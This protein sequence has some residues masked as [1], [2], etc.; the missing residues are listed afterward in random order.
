M[1]E[2]P[3]RSRIPAETPE[4]LFSSLSGVPP[5]RT[6]RRRRR[7]LNP[8]FTAG[9]GSGSRRRIPATPLVQWKFKEKVDPSGEITRKDMEEIGEVR[10]VVSA[11]RLAFWIWDL[12]LQDSS[13][14][15]K[16]DLR[17]ELNGNQLHFSYSSHGN[18]MNLYPDTNNE[19]INLP[20]QNHKGGTSHKLEPSA[21]L[22]HSSI[23]K[24]T[25]WDSGPQKFSKE[26]FDLY[27]SL[28]L[29]EDQQSNTISIISFL[30]SE[31]E[32]AQSRVSELEAE[33]QLAKK[34]FDRLIMKIEDAKAA[35]KKS[36]H[37][38][39]QSVIDAMKEDLSRERK[40]RKRLEI[41]NNKLI[42]EVADAKYSAKQFLVDYE[43]ET[44]ARVL[45]EEVCN[46]LAKEIEDDKAEV[47]AL[48]FESLKNREEVE[49][50]RR[51]LQM[52]EVWRE[53]RVQ[54][55]LIDAKIT[56]EEKYSQL[57]R[58]QEEMES[59]LRSRN[60]NNLD[61]SEISQAET[62]KEA[63]G[64]IEAG[65]IKELSYQPPS[66]SLDIFS[67]FEELQPRQE[68]NEKD[69]EQCC[70]LPEKLTNGCAGLMFDRN[71]NEEDDSGWE[72]VSRAEEDQDSSKSPDGSEPS[73]HGVYLE[74]R[75][76]ISGDDPKQNSE[77][78]EVFSVATNQSSKKSSSISRLWKLSRSSNA[79][80]FKKI[81]FEL[82]NG[83]LSNATLSPARKSGDTCL[84]SPSVGNWSSPDMLKSSIREEEMRGQPQWPRGSK[85][86]SLKS[87][88]MEARF[89]SQKIQLRQILEQKI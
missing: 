28:R 29:L 71:G 34:K 60:G 72:T 26:S 52:A 25:K 22:L 79:E 61:A 64:S 37:G 16:K 80:D 69:I 59:F 51:M 23:E 68:A 81:S 38:K 85:K 42:K 4:V 17:S 6:L 50:E 30:K 41:I 11:R 10:P 70:G 56:L 53:E 78:S 62:L 84:S 88:L 74:S 32:S 24:A 18:C 5:N 86:Q 89:Q 44:K 45:M 3:A 83:R 12:Q 9:G 13:G 63:V 15:E 73:V 20:R 1:S 46:E 75:A 39:I 49:E 58:L 27:G 21:S 40:C 48:K 35:W 7:S 65:D 2:L 66:S 19:S 77:I 43:K 55:K 8:V 14:G 36:E 54:M 76:S 87:K 47:E 82:T 67:I 57:S 31:L 33:Q